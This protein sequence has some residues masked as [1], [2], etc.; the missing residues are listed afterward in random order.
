MPNQ[1]SSRTID[2]SVPLQVAV[3]QFSSVT[4]TGG[5]TQPASATTVGT[6]PAGGRLWIQNVSNANEL[7]VKLGDAATTT[8]YDFKLPACTVTTAAGIAPPFLIEDYVGNV[9]IAGTTPLYTAVILS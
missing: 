6:V 3:P 9:T 8:N 2:D 4:R 7:Y 1:T 5:A